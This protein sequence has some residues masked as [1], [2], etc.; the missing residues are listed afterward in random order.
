MASPDRSQRD[1][2]ASDLYRLARVARERDRR[3]TEI[4]ARRGRE[5]WPGFDI[6][7]G[8]LTATGTPLERHGA[9]DGPVR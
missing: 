1:P 3:L 8:G 4:F 7:R 2:A 6:I 9:T 5:P